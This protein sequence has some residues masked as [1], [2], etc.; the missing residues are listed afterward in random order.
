MTC[1]GRAEPGAALTA[2]GADLKKDQVDGARVTVSVH[3]TRME[4]EDQE[5]S[6][7]VLPEGHLL[8]LS[9]AR[10]KEGEGADPVL[11]APPSPVKQEEDPVLYCILSPAQLLQMDAIT[12]QL[13]LQRWAK[14]ETWAQISGAGVELA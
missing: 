11:E 2:V 5:Q 3:C 4:W 7:R 9:W 10:L 1:A 13:K 12:S 8:I 6:C 14:E